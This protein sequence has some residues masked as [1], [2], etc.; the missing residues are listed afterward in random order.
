MPNIPAASPP[1]PKNNYPTPA[2]PPPVP[3]I[4]G[5]YAP[6]TTSTPAPPANPSA[7]QVSLD[8][9]ESPVERVHGDADPYSNLDGAFTNYVA[10]GPRPMQDI[11]QSGVEEDLLF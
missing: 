3:P 1:P 5:E 6:E 2:P 7:S 10:D 9:E 11:R 4:P 8:V